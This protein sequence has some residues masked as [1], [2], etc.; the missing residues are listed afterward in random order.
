MNHAL[1]LVAAPER[2]TREVWARDRDGDEVD[3]GSRAAVCWCA[4]GAILAANRDLYAGQGVL[5]IPVDPETGEATL[6]RGP[7]RVVV[8]LEALGAGFLQTSPERIQASPPSTLPGRRHVSLAEQH[9][10][11]LAS[12]INDLPLIKHPHVALALAWTMAALHDEL[13]R[14]GAATPTKRSQRDRRGAS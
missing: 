12:E 1:R 8:A 4:G 7:K 10:T 14:R 9:P 11:L 6:V 5:Q 13:E 3:A 2:W